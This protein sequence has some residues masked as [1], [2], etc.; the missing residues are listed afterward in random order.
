MS[1]AVTSW[2]GQVPLDPC[3]KVDGA[4]NGYIH[5][6]TLEQFAIDTGIV[7]GITKPNVPSDINYIPDYVSTNTC[8]LPVVTGT[9]Y[10]RNNTNRPMVVS[11]FIEGTTDYQNRDVNSSASIS[12]NLPPGLYDVTIRAEFTPPVN[13]PT[14][15]MQCNINGV[16]KI[17]NNGSLFHFENVTVPIDISVMPTTSPTN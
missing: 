10:A 3:V 14:L 13:G 17:T 16:T 9:L 4:N 11:F 6:I 2:R 12:E 8:P 5:I 7:T 15:H 1:G